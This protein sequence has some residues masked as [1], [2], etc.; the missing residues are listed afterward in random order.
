MY[1]A[2]GWNAENMFFLTRDGD[3]TITEVGFPKRAEGSLFY[4][5]NQCLYEYPLTSE[6]DKFGRNATDVM[7][8]RLCGLIPHT[9]RFK[10]LTC[11]GVEGIYYARVELDGDIVEGELSHVVDVFTERANGNGGK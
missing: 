9:E 2:F 1:E 5:A 6:T 10:S 3:I 8:I 11:K 4:Y 7:F